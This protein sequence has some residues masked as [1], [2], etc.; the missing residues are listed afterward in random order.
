[1][2]PHSWDEQ[3]DTALPELTMVRPGQS[4]PAQG[5]VNLMSSSFGFGGNNFSLILSYDFD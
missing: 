3:A 5:K 4:I 2:P 1:L